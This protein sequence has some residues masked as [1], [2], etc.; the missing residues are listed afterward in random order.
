VSG[1]AIEGER[2]GMPRDFVHFSKRFWQNSHRKKPIKPDVSS[3]KT[4]EQVASLLLK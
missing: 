1:A 3:A 4:V 2:E